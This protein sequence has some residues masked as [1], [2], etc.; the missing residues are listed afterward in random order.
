[1]IHRRSTFRQFFIFKNLKLTL[2]ISLPYEFFLQLHSTLLPRKQGNFD[3]PIKLSIVECSKILNHSCTSPR[4][5]IVSFED[6][7]IRREDKSWI[8][9]FTFNNNTV[10]IV[11]AIRSAFIRGKETIYHAEATCPF[12]VLLSFV[13]YFFSSFLR[14]V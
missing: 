4:C 10:T 5:E 3:F 12:F 2:S 8:I 6:Q 11:V 13:F 14:V 7:T 9:T 1:M